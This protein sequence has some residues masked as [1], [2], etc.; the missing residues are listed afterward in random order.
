VTLEQTTFADLIAPI[1]SPASEDGSTRLSLLVGLGIARSGPAPAPA[2]RSRSQGRGKGSQTTG[3]SGPSSCDSSLSGVLQRSLESRLRVLLEG[4][5]SPEYVL[6]WKHW[7]MQSGP[8][9]CALRASGHRTS[10]SGCSGWQTASAMSQPSTSSTSIEGCSAIPHLT[11]WPSPTVGNAD[12]SQMAKDAS[13][14]DRHPDG[15]K[16]TVSLNHVASLAGWR[17]PDSG[18]R[19]G[20]YADPEK[21]LAR[22]ESGH[23]VNL[24]DQAVLAGWPTPVA[25]DDNKTPEAHLA[26]KQRMG[27][28]DGSGANRTQI[29]SLQVM[30]QTAGWATPTTK[31]HKD[32]D[33]DLDKNPVNALLG[34]QSLLSSVRTERRGALNP[35]HSRWL[36]GYPAEWDAYA[37]TATRSSRKSRPRS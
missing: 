14:T 28:R 8:P 5:G 23:Q 10:G 37:P 15:S 24:N 1:S 13:A 19:G 6:T 12:G 36:M 16:A 4:R 20:D 35:A 34:R 18:Q 2:S 22:M 21:A 17:S 27:E 3:T 29:T 33:C 11:G 9:I 30:V 7:D 26:M 25:N 32:G 31:D